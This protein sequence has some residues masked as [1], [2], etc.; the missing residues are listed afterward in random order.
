MPAINSSYA[1]HIIPGPQSPHGDEIIEARHDMIAPSLPPQSHA[2]RV[3]SGQ[4]PPAP[5]AS[6]NRSVVAAGIPAFPG[7]MLSLY[8][9]MDVV[10]L[11]DAVKNIEE[12]L[13]CMFFGNR[14]TAPVITPCL[15]FFDAAALQQHLR[16]NSDDSCPDCRSAVKANGGAEPHPGVQTLVD[17]Y[18]AAFDTVLVDETG[19]AM[20]VADAWPEGVPAEHREL[21]MSF[22]ERFDELGGLP[23]RLGYLDGFEILDQARLLMRALRLAPG[24]GDVALQL[25]GVA[26]QAHEIRPAI[27][28]QLA[29][30]HL[31]AA[32]AEVFFMDG[33]KDAILNGL[34]QLQQAVVRD[35][36]MRADRR[37]EAGYLALDFTMHRDD[38]ISRAAVGVYASLLGVR[39]H[40]ALTSLAEGRPA[41]RHA[42]CD[43]L[44]AQ[45]PSS[46][47]LMDVLLLESTSNDVA[48]QEPLLE[49]LRL[50]QQKISEQRVDNEFLIM[51]V[52]ELLENHIDA[53]RAYAAQV[54][55]SAFA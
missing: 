47:I 40:N 8:R 36:D 30:L 54:Y 42:I 33:D 20:D 18:S 41:V 39:A 43:A 24:N 2:A 52:A 50:L 28:A 53:V 34:T 26:Q 7:S 4:V 5:S 16:V 3:V 10:Q 45:D 9:A 51:R 32:A 15:H 25:V 22:L 38:D 44:R 35:P 19:A 23:Q 1:N 29:Q 49:G 11:R 13:A 21:A 14:M 55:N 12:G 48:A 17:A 6:V 31:H 46:D 27:A 37:E